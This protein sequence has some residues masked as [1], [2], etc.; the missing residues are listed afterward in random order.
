MAVDFTK[1]EL[2]IRRE[3]LDLW[4]KHQEL[5]NNKQYPH[6][7][8]DGPLYAIG[9]HK[10]LRFLFRDIFQDGDYSDQGRKAELAA[11]P[12]QGNDQ[13]NGACAD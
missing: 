13:P 6:D 7:K 11:E 12:G 4:W 5:I 2:L 10:A 1:N 3:L 9:A 8:Q